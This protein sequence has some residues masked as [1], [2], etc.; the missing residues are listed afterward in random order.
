MS[1]TAGANIIFFVAALIV[2]ASVA[3]VLREGV[4]DLSE[5]LQDQGEENREL[6]SFDAE[7]VADLDRIPYDGDDIRVYLK[8]TGSETMDPENVVVLIDGLP[9]PVIGR[10]V[11]AGPTSYTANHPPVSTYILSGSADGTAD[12][13]FDDVITLYVNGR[14]ERV[15]GCCNSP[16]IHFQARYGDTLSITIENLGGPGYVGDL[17]LVSEGQVVQLTPSISP[18]PLGDGDPPVMLF[19]QSFTLGIPALPSNVDTFTYTL[20]GTSDGLTPFW[21]D[22]N[23]YIYVNELLISGGA[24]PFVGDTGSGPLSFTARQRDEL[25][26]IVEDTGKG[27]TGLGDL[28]LVQGQESVRINDRLEYCVGGGCGG[29]GIDVPDYTGTSYVYYDRTFTISLPNVRSDDEILLWEPGAVLELVVNAPDLVPADP[30]SFELLPHRLK[31]EAGTGP[32]ARSYSTDIYFIP[33]DVN[34]P[35]VSIGPVD[36]TEVAPSSITTGETLTFKKSVADDVGIAYVKVFYSYTTDPALQKVL[37]LYDDGL[38]RDDGIRDRVYANSIPAP[39]NGTAISYYFVISD[40]SGNLAQLS[41]QLATIID[42]D[43]P[44]FLS[45]ITQ[46]TRTPGETILFNVSVIDNVRIQ[47]VACVVNELG[48]G[49]NSVFLL[50]NVPGTN[51]Y[52]DVYVSGNNARDIRYRFRAQDDSGLWFDW[53][54]DQDFL[55]ETRDVDPPGI[56]A[57]VFEGYFD[58]LT[59]GSGTFGTFYAGNASRIQV[60]VTEDSG[61][62]REVVLL[63]KGVDETTWHEAPLTDDG[64]TGTD[65]WA[66]DGVYT[67]WFDVPSL[68]GDMNIRYRLVDEAG[69]INL[70]P[71]ETHTLADIAFPNIYATSGSTPDSTTG[72]T[73]IVK[74]RVTDNVGVERVFANYTRPDILYILSGSS[75]SAYSSISFD[76][77][78]Y[79]FVNDQLVQV[80]NYCCGGQPA[81]FYA[82]PG[83]T[84]GLIAVDLGGVRVLGDLFLHTEGEPVTQV[85]VSPGVAVSDATLVFENTSFIIPQMTQTQTAIHS[86][87]LFDD[88]LHGDEEAGDGIYAAYVTLPTEAISDTLTVTAVDGQGNWR[89]LDLTYQADLNDGPGSMKDLSYVHPQESGWFQFQ[90]SLEAPQVHNIRYDDLGGVQTALHYRIAGGSWNNITIADYWDTGPRDSLRSDSFISISTHLLSYPLALS[91]NVLM[92]RDVEYYWSICRLDLSG[93]AVC[94]NLPETTTYVLEFDDREAPMNI[95][96]SNFPSPPSPTT[97]D[98]PTLVSFEIWDDGSYTTGAGGT[99][100][101]QGV[102]HSTVFIH[103]RKVAS[104]GETQTEF[105]TAP[106]AHYLYSSG[107][108]YFLHYIP[109]DGTATTWEYFVTGADRAGNV[110]NSS[111]YTFTRTDS[112]SPDIIHNIDQGARTGRNYTVECEFTDHGDIASAVL[113]YYQ[114]GSGVPENVTMQRVGTSNAY[115]A[116]VTMNLQRG[117]FLYLITIADDDGNTAD[118]GKNGYRASPPVSPPQGD[119]LPVEVL[120][121]TKPDVKAQTFSITESTLQDRMINATVTDNDAVAQV[122]LY[123]LL[124]GA[125]NYTVKTMLPAGGDDYRVTLNTSAR[126]GTLRYYVV[127]LDDAGNEA[128]SPPVNPRFS[129]HSINVSDST[130]ATVV[131]SVPDSVD[132]DETISLYAQIDDNDGIRAAL[133]HYHG[134]DE[135]WVA[136]G[137]P[138]PFTTL[139]FQ[140]V[141]LG[142]WRV[143]LPPETG[144]MT[145]GVAGSTSCRRIEYYIEVEDMNGTITVSPSFTGATPSS[146][147]D[148][149]NLTVV[150]TYAPR[151][152]NVVSVVPPGYSDAIPGTTGDPI[153]ISVSAVDNVNV[154]GGGLSLLYYKKDGVGTYTEVAFGKNTESGPGGVDEIRADIQIPTDDRTNL[155]YYIEVSDSAGNLVRYPTSGNF[156]ITVTDNDPPTPRFPLTLLHPTNG[157]G[158]FYPTTGESFNISVNFTDN[159]AVTGA[160]LNYQLVTSCNV[161]DP[162]ERP[163][164]SVDMI[165]ISEGYYYANNDTMGVETTSCESDY[166]Y[167]ITVQ[168]AS[169]NTY[170]YENHTGGADFFIYVTDNDGPVWVSGSGNILATT[171]DDF[172][173]Y[174]NWTDLAEQNIGS[175]LWV[176]NDTIGW[177]PFMRYAEV[178]NAPPDGVDHFRYSYLIET[179]FRIIGSNHSI[180]QIFNTSHGGVFYFY[181][182]GNDSLA[183]AFDGNQTS[184]YTITVSDNDPPTVGITETTN[185]TSVGTG[186]AVVFHYSLRDNIDTSSVVMYYRRGGTIDDLSGFSPIPPPM[187]RTE[188]LTRGRSEDFTISNVNLNNMPEQTKSDET[189]WFY[190]VEAQDAQGNMFNSTDFNGQP[191]QITI[192]DNDAPVFNDYTTDPVRVN[193]TETFTIYCNATDNMDVTKVQIHYRVG[194]TDP[195]EIRDMTKTGG[196]GAF[197]RSTWRVTSAEMDVITDNDNEEIYFYFVL[198]DDGPG[199]MDTYNGTTGNPHILYVDDRTF[200]VIDTG[201]SIGNFTTTTGWPDSDNFTIE[202]FVSDN[203]DMA[204]T[205]CVLGI[206]RADEDTYL[207]VTMTKSEDL[208]PGEIERFTTNYYV[209]QTTHPSV[210]LS[211]NDDWHFIMLL[212]DTEVP[213]NTAI[214]SWKNTLNSPFVIT[215][216][217]NDDPIVDLGPGD[218]SVGTGDTIFINISARDNDDIASATLFFRTSGTTVYAQYSMLRLVER[219]SGLV[220]E[221]TFTATNLTTNS[222]TDFDYYA[223]FTDP[224]GNSF[225]YDAGGSPYTVSVV[226]DDLAVFTDVTTLPSKLSTGAT[227]D[228]FFNFTDNIDTQSAVMFHKMDAA[229]AYTQTILTRTFNGGAGQRDTWST[230]SATMGVDTTNDDRTIKYYVVLTDQ[231]DLVTFHGTSGAPQELIVLDDVAPVFDSATGSFSVGTDND[232]T[233]YANFTDNINVENAFIRLR[234]LGSTV[235]TLTVAMDPMLNGSAGGLDR[236]QIDYTTLKGSGYDTSDGVDWEYSIIADDTSLLD[237]TAT[238]PI[239]R[240]TTQDDDAPTVNSGSGSFSVMTGSDF[241]ISLTVDE[242]VDTDSAALYIREAGDVTYRGPFT[243]VRETDGTPSPD[244]FWLTNRHLDIDTTGDPDDLEYYILLQDTTGNTLDYSL[245][246]GPYIITVVDDDLPTEIDVRWEPTPSVTTGEVFTLHLNVSDNYDVLQVTLYWR[247]GGAGAFSPLLMTK[248]SDSGPGGIDR[249]SATSTDMGADTT[250]DETDIDYYFVVYDGTNTPNFG[251]DVAPRTLSIVDDDLPTSPS[252]SGNIAV[253]TSDDFTIFID[254]QD[255]DDPQSA[256]IGMR[257]ADYPIF[258]WVDMGKLTDA[259][260]GGLD[261][262][263]VGYLGV[264]GLNVLSTAFIDTDDA[265]DWEYIIMVNDTVNSV[266]FDNDGMPWTVTVTDNDGPVENGPAGSQNITGQDP[267]TPFTILA[268]FT[269]NA[270]GDAG[271]QSATLYYKDLG[272]GAYSSVSMVEG[273]DGQFMLPSSALADVLPF[274]SGEN[275]VYYV[276]CLDDEGNEGYAGLPARPYVISMA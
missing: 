111:I 170:S 191:Y 256:V 218:F 108:D 152:T 31:V 94:T 267:N 113:T 164:L 188:D 266:V 60:T 186:D 15:I 38:H 254:V 199:S 132:A 165:R 109:T 133:I 155:S 169:G 128:T 110:G 99:S 46:E 227:F 159:I 41:N 216:N 174:G 93:N 259:P 195:Y 65:S 118:Y 54:A 249:F 17:F 233:V 37:T 4:A 194:T 7:L 35:Y 273:Q 141:S 20:S 177:K 131:H 49:S 232:F 115:R 71:I 6:L 252:G 250:N 105:T 52:S 138:E 139:S 88:G 145:C 184:P 34:P 74:V 84:V 212:N 271:A 102:D 198:F 64:L 207:W 104:V 263:T 203:V 27:V 214:H 58:S 265:R 245:P 193:T 189:V 127:A 251:T 85:Y 1:G 87:E 274:T 75:V 201:S 211:D 95:A 161:D 137:N 147:A 204:A 163:H 122:L 116:T 18:A 168:D 90:L 156:S 192:Y 62:V 222:I 33:E 57:N 269:D 76:D 9:F 190:F 103:Y 69:N 21:H 135:G 42:N 157:P 243:M 79:I 217:D 162:D 120:D 275:I 22:D 2:A 172:E 208:N 59:Q 230:D 129:S 205:D 270:Y 81:Y 257:R 77:E 23:A 229:E 40:T 100:A 228:V 107:R 220:D 98:S 253:T 140:E 28:Y 241:S 150:D 19:N 160:V 36:N 117:Q 176:R 236:F 175:T 240:I 66:A 5:G 260:K 68:P 112:I 158:D 130:P 244:T 44:V 32:T 262:F 231:A 200:P 11:V 239:Y 144:G 50:N 224:D 125:Q 8:N 209:I 206:K 30:N 134:V 55:M 43:P 45:D 238:S 166:H 101:N 264:S 219:D 86:T 114:V 143:L 248:D 151:I 146:P 56:F 187:S 126:A 63:W 255:N 12:V 153:T 167:N 121:T 268:I 235:Y 24:L 210:N 92:G 39:S 247:V 91:D 106:M 97:H 83:D 179:D 234:T 154:D 123:Y 26:I 29:G 181:H 185:D 51:Y 272:G 258:R 25:R 73:T 82:T 10:N 148:L 89:G 72:E 142:L 202:A 78:L 226:D 53:P 119:F 182:E 124:P 225:T 14:T 16:P 13:G 96:Q 136:P 173:I 171:G 196:G 149:H 246:G 197:T 261:R 48:A 221:F 215:V 276:V 180:V 223:V 80:Y 70:T 3:V 178:N 61:M 213:P 67:G 237:N 47:N 183:S 242:N